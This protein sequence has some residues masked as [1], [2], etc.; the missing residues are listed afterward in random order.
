MVMKNEMLKYAEEKAR[1]RCCCHLEDEFVTEAQFEERVIKDLDRARGRIVICSA[2]LT[3]EGSDRFKEAILRARARGVIVCLYVQEPINWWRREGGGLKYFKLVKL[4]ALAEAIKFMESLGVHVNL[5]KGIHEKVVIVDDHISWFGSLNMSSYTGETSEL[6]ERKS[7]PRRVRK[8]VHLLRLDEC[9]HCCSHLGYRTLLLNPNATQLSGT[10]NMKASEYTQLIGHLVKRIRKE[11]NLS[12]EQ[13][14]QAAGIAVKT[15]RKLESGY[16]VRRA[17]VEKVCVA[18][19]MP[20]LAV[21]FHLVPSLFQFFCKLCSEHECM[22]EFCIGPAEI[23]E[24]QKV[25]RSLR[26]NLGLT[27]EESAL[28][29]GLRQSQISDIESGT[30]AETL[31]RSQELCNA[32]G[33]AL[34]PII[35]T[36][37]GVDE[38][39]KEVAS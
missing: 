19:S 20:L 1:C 11:R 35:A 23:V 39:L 8:L 15:I 5:V 4:N 37:P 26:L 21:P 12:K 22:R 17:L 25:L 24:I 14:S 9:E 7:D 31:N 13:L 34:L 28:V 16:N 3:M 38:Y 27:Q 18:L 36:T 10:K 6:M 30:H 2:Y 29:L 33:L 32:Y